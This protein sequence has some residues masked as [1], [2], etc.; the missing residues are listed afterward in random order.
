VLSDD[1]VSSL[2][3]GRGGDGGDGGGGDSDGNEG[4]GGGAAAAFFLGRY[5]GLVKPQTPQNSYFS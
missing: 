3:R 2:T 5:L 4:G 1:V